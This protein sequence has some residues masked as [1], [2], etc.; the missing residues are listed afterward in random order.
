MKPEHYSSVIRLNSEIIV[1]QDV[2][3]KQIS[4]TDPSMFEEVAIRLSVLKAELAS[5]Q[6][7]RKA[8]LDDL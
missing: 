3:L 7:E 4:I 8:F 5:L 1:I 2:I 6:I